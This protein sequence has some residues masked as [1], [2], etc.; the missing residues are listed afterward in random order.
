[1]RAIDY[2]L[3]QPPAR[4]LV[5][6]LPG[7]GDDA[8]AFSHHGLVDD[9]ERQRLSIDVVAANATIGYYTR[10]T[11]A[12]R[13]ASDVIEPRR[14]AR[15]YQQIWLIG[16]SMGGFGTLWYAHQHLSEVTGV[17]ALSPFLGDRDLIEEVYQAGGLQRWKAPPRVDQLN[18][19]NYQRELLRW[20]QA[21]TRGQEP[22]PQLSLGFGD[23]DKLARADEVLA[24]V[25]P[26]DRVYRDNGGHEWGSWRRLLGQFLERG[27][28]AR[29]CA[30]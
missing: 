2:P 1:M 29:S 9:L 20:L 17:L 21:A 3:A 28:L 8:E 30:R 27:P 5:V 6:L 14:Q 15:G 13:L 19:K 16:N 22:A 12:E 10:G 4:C 23:R 11:F 26:A 24:G 7:M 25:L 18:D